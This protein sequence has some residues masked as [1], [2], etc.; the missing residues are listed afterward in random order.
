MVLLFQGEQL[1]IPP[2]RPVAYLDVPDKGGRGR[3][4]WYLRDSR[5][6]KIIAEGPV[7]GYSTR[8]KAVLAAV[9]VS[10]YHWR[11]PALEEDK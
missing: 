6:H 5:S 9:A 8:N 7:N 11:I 1:P 2:R 3:Y 10:G 4:R